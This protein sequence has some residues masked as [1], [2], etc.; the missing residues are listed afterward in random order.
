MKLSRY[1]REC[2][3]AFRTGKYRPWAADDWMSKDNWQLAA[4][5]AEWAKGHA[6]A[7]EAMRESEHDR[8][9]MAWGWC[10]VQAFQCFMGWATR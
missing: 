6:N 10:W 3:E 9:A 1:D 5:Y 4:M 7:V 2:H 8:Q